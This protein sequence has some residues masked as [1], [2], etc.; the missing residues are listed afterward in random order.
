M[1]FCKY[2]L[3][4]INGIYNFGKTGVRNTLD[5]CFDDFFGRKSNIKGAIDMYF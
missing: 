4:G 2:F 5:K 1:P 3:C